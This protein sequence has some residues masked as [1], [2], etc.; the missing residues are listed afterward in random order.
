MLH[1]DPVTLDDIRALDAV[2]A[3]ICVSIYLPTS[4]VTSEGFVD[5]I[6]YKNLVTDALTQLT[7]GGFNKRRI[8]PIEEHLR[9]LDEDDD[10][11][12]YMAE[13]LA[14]FATPDH[15]EYYRIAASPA[16]RMDIAD[17]FHLKPLAPAAVFSGLA[18]VLALSQGAVRLIEVSPLNAD[19][20]RVPDMPKDMSDALGRQFPRDPAPTGRIQGQ[21]GMTV[22]TNQYVHRVDQALRPYLAGRE[23]PLIVAAVDDVAVKFRQASGY[24]HVVEEIISGNPETK[25]AR[26]LAESARA[27]LAA[28]QRK[29][30]KTMIEDYRQARASDLASSDLAMVARGAVFGQIDTLLLD[31]DASQPGRLDKETGGI[32]PA[33]SDG[34]ED[35]DLIDEIMSQTLRNGG[36]V[37]PIKS[38]DLPDGKN[39]A[40]LFRYKMKG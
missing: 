5:R 34:P 16:V 25:S 15:L 7:E 27:V 38:S 4:V 39:I 36:K 2:R 24:R 12:A 40:A 8:W 13:G 29:K 33:N 22:L 30:V 9:S 31:P 26:Q 28:R 11:W 6:V 19:E 14:A 1:T 35:Y 3:D 17:R 37:F 10:F 18:Y 23:I 21:E 32:V 20:V